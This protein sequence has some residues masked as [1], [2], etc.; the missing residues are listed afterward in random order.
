MA[1]SHLGKPLSYSHK[2]K[3]M[4]KR[5]FPVPSRNFSLSMASIAI[6][7]VTA[8]PI[9]AQQN[10]PKDYLSPAFHAGRRE[11]LRAKMPPNSVTVIFSY[12]PRTFSKDVTYPYHPNP[13]LYYF[14]GYKEPNAVLLIFK[15]PQKGTGGSI[16]K[17]LFFIQKRDLAE[18]QWTGRRLGLEK[19]KSQLGFDSV[20]NGSDFKDFPIGFSSF[21]KIL[22]AALP[23]DVHD[24]P[25]D[26][27]DLFDLIHAFR[28]NAALP[29]P[30]ELRVNWIIGYLADFANPGNLAGLLEYTHA[31][32]EA[33]ET[34]RNNEL[35]KAFLQCKDSASLAEFKK[36]ALSPEIQPLPL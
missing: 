25:N 26:P 13:D 21:D 9:R 19:V 15:D 30:E 23:D 28:K 7:L 14:S 34:V 32:A 22:F 17:E 12:P 20:Y 5:D 33:N 3:D 18:E 2:M 11:A 36:K 6:L 8:I 29:D 35:V 4:Q 24:D 16:Y 1:I 27:A 31:R 10:L